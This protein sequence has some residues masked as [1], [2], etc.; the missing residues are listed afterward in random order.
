MKH[1]FT[2]I[3]K[4]GSK[5]AELNAVI[6]VKY[7]AQYTF[8]PDPVALKFVYSRGT[9]W[10]WC[11]GFAPLLPQSIE[12]DKELDKALNSLWSGKQEAIAEF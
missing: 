2:F 9:G 10:I 1:F 7:R 4:R 12:G 8:L 5:R 11:G 6:E 3:N